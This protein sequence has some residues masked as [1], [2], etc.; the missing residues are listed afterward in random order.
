MPM[1]VNIKFDEYR[2]NIL[3]LKERTRLIWTILDGQ[4]KDH[5]SGATRE[6]RMV[7]ELGLDIRPIDIIQK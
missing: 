4:F 3:R 1:N 6:I 5:N 2:V 7:I